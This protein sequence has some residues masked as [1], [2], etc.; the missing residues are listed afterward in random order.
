M[1]VGCW[2]AHQN[3][4][5]DLAWASHDRI[6]TGSGD[7]TCRLFDVASTREIQVFRGHTGS[8]KAVS[9]KPVEP[10][11]FASSARDGN[12]L[13]W[14][15]RA[16]GTPVVRIS[17]AHRR[18][19]DTGGAKRK[20]GGDAVASVGAAQSVSSLVYLRNATSMLATAGA[21]D[22]TV[23]VWD[24]RRSS[25]GSSSSRGQGR[26]GKAR[27]GPSADATPTPVHV[28]GPNVGPSRKPHGVACIATDASGSKLLVNSCD[29]RIYLYDTARLLAHGGGGAPPPVA[30]A[31]LHGHRVDTFYIKAC[32][33]PDGNFVLGGSSDEAAFVW[34]VSRP[35]APP[36]ALR[37][38]VG[39]VTCVAWSPDDFGTVLSGSDDATVRVW[40]LR[41]GKAMAARQERAAEQRAAAAAAAYE[42]AAQRFNA[43]PPQQPA[44][45][46]DLVSIPP[47]R[48]ASSGPEVDAWPMAGGALAAWQQRSS[49]ITC[50]EEEA[51]ATAAAT[52]MAAT[53]MA[54]T[55]S[56]TAAGSAAATAGTCTGAPTD[57]AAQSDVDMAEAAAPSAGALRPLVHEASAAPATPGTV[58]EGEPC[59]GRAPEEAS[60]AGGVVTPLT[61][62]ATGS[63]PSASSSAQTEQRSRQ[64]SSSRGSVEPDRGGVQQRHLRD[65]FSRRT[66]AAAAEE[67]D[68]G[69]DEDE[70]LVIA[71]AQKEAAERARLAGELGPSGMP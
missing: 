60:R 11:T 8:V 55:A 28:V 33:S 23:K 31:Q 47:R 54:A 22:G 51:V 14:D 56:A 17:G 70:R 41:R 4:L 5:F 44:S 45:T 2:R 37:G 42:S 62:M 59:V 3:A 19:M 7:Q 43:V 34:D 15:A 16:G 69:D 49:P 10:N 36:V 1:R 63:G 65:Y 18:V 48:E 32:F 67:E 38:H 40:S 61:A 30:Q 68:D 25:G 27:A 39:E 57:V 13:I 20:R 24:L 66:S 21:T 12:V 58:R 6:L 50:E 52:S 53:S 46:L 64:R 29:S 26:G 35:D 9:V 71:R